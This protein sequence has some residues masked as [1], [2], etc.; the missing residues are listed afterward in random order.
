M[1]KVKRREFLHR[2]ANRRAPFLSI[3]T[4]PESCGPQRLHPATSV[5][6]EMAILIIKYC[7][8]SLLTAGMNTSQARRGGHRQRGSLKHLIQRCIRSTFLLLPLNSPLKRQGGPSHSNS[9]LWL[10]PPFVPLPNSSFC[11][12]SL[13]QGLH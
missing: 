7:E 3:F 4:W 12:R 8:A 1:M 10:C 6:S 11:S 5:G 2:V 9:Q 13:R